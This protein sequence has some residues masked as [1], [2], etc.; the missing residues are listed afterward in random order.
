MTRA[1]G[2]SILLFL[3]S[4]SIVGCAPADVESINVS[5][6][7]ADFPRSSTAGGSAT[8]T[9]R[10]PTIDLPV[11]NDATVGQQFAVAPVASDLDGDQLTFDIVNK[12]QW[13]TFDAQSGRLA[14][15]PSGSDV[16]EVSGVTISVSDGKIRVSAPSIS[17]RV[18]SATPSTSAANR[19]PVLSGSPPNSATVSVAY[20]YTWSA[21]DPDGDALTFSIVNLPSWASFDTASGRLWGT[22]G[23]AD[24]GTTTSVQVSVSDGKSSTSLPPFLL[25]VAAAAATGIATLEW[26]APTTN[27]DGTPLTDLAGYVIVY[28]RAASALSQAVSI[29]DAAIKSHVVGGLSTGTWY[30]AVKAINQSGRESPISSVS[31]KVI[32]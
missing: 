28:G 2:I 29:S 15:T 17:I 11:A 12:P 27:V 13:A 25:T 19:A 7:S 26:I 24:A 31:S 14:G 5:A 1:L 10:A 20:A 23:F 4:V 32:P 18:A 30:F 6:N 16:G 9:N 21:V 3:S 22:P 8:G